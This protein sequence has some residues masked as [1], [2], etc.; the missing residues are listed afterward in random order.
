MKIPLAS[1]PSV[2]CTSTKTTAPCN[3]PFPT[4]FRGLLTGVV[5]VDLVTAEGVGGGRFSSS[6]STSIPSRVESPKSSM[7]NDCCP[8]VAAA[9]DFERRS[10]EVE[11]TVSVGRSSDV[12]KIGFFAGDCP[13]ES[14]LVLFLGILIGEI[15]PSGRNGTLET[16]VFAN[17]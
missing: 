10:G 8:G 1:A 11:T 15:W 17:L 3:A 4:S 9:E 13:A 7:T 5:N 16:I 12:A 6:S 14:D 2:V